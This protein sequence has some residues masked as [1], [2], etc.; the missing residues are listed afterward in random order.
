MKLK[1]LLILSI[2]VGSFLGLVIY[3]GITSE[4][5]QKVQNKET[6]QKVEVY[7]TPPARLIIE[8]IGV[9]SYVEKVGIDDLGRM[10]V[11]K[12]FQNTGWLIP[13]F[14][15]YPGDKGN[16][17]IDG[18][19]DTPDGGPAVFYNL[20]RLEVGD[21]IKVIT[22]ENKELEF[23]I[24]QKELYPHD[25]FPIELVFGKTNERMLNLITCDGVF[26]KKSSI[27][28]HRLVVFSKLVSD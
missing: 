21:R 23:E 8:K 27:Y 3:R 14:G 11:P 20:A 7:N 6:V 18:H 22:E 28:S 2:F 16:A 10:D 1:Y 5:P 13:K 25:K 12:D 26:D 17:T 15:F 4:E 9:D 24:T 19:F